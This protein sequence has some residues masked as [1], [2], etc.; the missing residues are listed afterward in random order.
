MK[1]TKEKLLKEK[2]KIDEQLRALELSEEY[3]EVK[4]LGIKIIKT[5]KFNGKKYAEIIQE[6]GE[7][8]IATNKILQD[9][10][11][12][13]F[14]SKWKKYPFMKKFWVFVPNKDKQSKKNGKAARFVADSGYAYLGCGRVSD[15]SDSDLGVFLF[16][17]LE[18]K[19]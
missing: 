4:E 15:G 3:V 14:D 1:K 16:E 19:Q 7:E 8:K 17:K 2:K 13:S 18:K 11:N 9:L 5:Q 6:V 12:I 10:R